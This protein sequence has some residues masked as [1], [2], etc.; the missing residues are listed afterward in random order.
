[1]GGGNLE[2]MNKLKEIST[3]MN[4]K[5]TE[6]LLKNHRSTLTHIFDKLEYKDNEENL[7]E[8][9][10]TEFLN[11]LPQDY[12]D[13]FKKMGKSFQELAGDDNV[14]DIKEFTLILDEW[15]DQHM[16]KR[17]LVDIDDSND[18]SMSP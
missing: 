5:W 14:I 6:S 11:M 7:S 4:K 18:Y 3:K 16:S 13:A 10:F 9:E 1:M 2:T 12:Q 8:Q 15:V 17:R